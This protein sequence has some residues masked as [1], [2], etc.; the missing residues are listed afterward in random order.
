MIDKH[1]II[2]VMG[3]HEK[4]WEDYATPLGKLIAE[5]DYHLLTGAGPGAMTAVAKAFC[6]VEDR[7]GMSIGIVP[8]TEYQGGFVNREEYP[9]PYIEIPIITPLDKKAQSATNPYS[10][11]YVNVMTSHALVFLPGEYG[12]QNEASLALMFKKPSLFFG[13]ED[14]FSDFPEKRTHVDDIEGVRE[15]LESTTAQFRTEYED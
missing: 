7:L 13:P 2:G 5:H 10:R 4:S 8:T 15:F 12:T 3:S 1:P 14:A 6:D 9:N 11:N